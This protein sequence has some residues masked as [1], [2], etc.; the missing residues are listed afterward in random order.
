MAIDGYQLIA[1]QDERLAYEKLLKATGEDVSW[2]GELQFRG[3]DFDD[4]L[5][6]VEK[7]VQK[8]PN[9]VIPLARL[10]YL[11]WQNGDVELAQQT[12]ESLRETSGSLDLHVPLFARLQPIA[13]SLEL[14]DQW[15]KP[16]AP[17]ADLG[18]RP[19]LDT[20]GPFRWS[21]PTAPNG[22]WW[23]PMN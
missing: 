6:T 2:L 18:F 5:E 3:G 16:Y 9:E 14:R 19:P 22:H 21:P 17:S 20:L 8:R 11:Q 12:F 15:Q 4:G 10:A 7:Q 23:I 13:D 1:A